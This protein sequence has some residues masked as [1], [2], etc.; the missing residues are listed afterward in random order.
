MNDRLIEAGAFNLARSVLE[1]SRQCIDRTRNPRD[2]N[3]LF[4]ATYRQPLSMQRITYS[5]EAV[6]GDQD[7]QPNACRLNDVPAGQ[8]VGLDCWEDD[9][10]VVPHWSARVG[11]DG[12]Q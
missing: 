5:D 11:V 7:D 6:D 9:V 12:L 4:G 8:D 10:I 2:G 1:K 3:L